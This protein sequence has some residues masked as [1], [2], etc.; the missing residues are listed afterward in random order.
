MDRIA[1]FAHKFVLRVSLIALVL[2]C[3]ALAAAP[4]S[5]SVSP[6][7]KALAAPTRLGLE[8]IIVLGTR[9]PNKQKNLTASVGLIDQEQIA[10]SSG[11]YVLD[12]ISAAPSVYVSKDNIYGRQ[13]MNIRG[14]GSNMRRIQT[15]VDGRPEKMSLF[16]CT[17]PQSLS[18]ANV[19]RVEIMRGAGSALYG[20]DALGGVVNVITRR[21]YDPG[22]ETEGLFKYGSYN[23]WNAVGRHGGKVEDFDY[24]VT[25][26]HKQTDGYRKNSEYVADFAA[27]RLGQDLNDNWHLQL[28]GQFLT[29]LGHDPGPLSEPYVND[30]R[31]QYKRGAWN[32]DLGGQWEDSRF[33]LMVYEN[34]GENDFHLP[35]INDY[36][37]SKDA[38]Y[39]AKTEYARTVFEKDE[40]KSTAG[41]GYEYQ[42]L[43]ARPQDDWVAWAQ[44][45][46]PAKYMSLSSHVQQNNDLYAFNELVWG[47]WVNN[48]AL[49]AHIDNVTS[50]IELLPEIGLLR[51]LTDSTSL[52]ARA[53]RGFRQPRFSELYLF[54]AH[55]EDLQPEE[56]W[57][58]DL[59]LRQ[60]LGSWA[61][62]EITPFYQQVHNM[63]QTVGNPQPPPPV[64]NQNSGAFDARGLELALELRPI[65]ANRWQFAYTYSDIDEAGSLEPHSN[66]SGT[67]RHDLHCIVEYTLQKLR[68]AAELQYVNDLYNSDIQGG[69]PI[70]KISNYCVVNLKAAYGVLPNAEV[71]AE[72]DNLFDKSYQ[73]VPG[74]PMPG[75]TG[76]LGLRA[77]L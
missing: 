19:E 53:A 45:N 63:I 25:Y 66:R 34:F 12:V 28:G 23:T 22:F 61:S 35:T 55:N 18:L 60:S 65:A 67:P 4:E 24:Y 74:Y 41:L 42:Y 3:A 43:W 52:R 70:E 68:L 13:D 11:T 72:V 16:G 2:P 9:L 44:A 31:R 30:D 77:W 54:P 58:Y 39:G 7:P 71:F 8:E 51:H 57:S 49:R 46:M 50:D 5:D 29:D 27:L 32:I 40:L 21:R 38:S 6:A 36:W 73:Q 37:H 15:L 14:L 47:R 17:I 62:L 69:G 10:A 1:A 20:S 59:G 48:L 56:I 64:S 76:Y 33:L 26:D 75:I